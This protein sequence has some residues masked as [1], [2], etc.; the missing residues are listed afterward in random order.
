M[1]GLRVVAVDGYRLPDGSWS[2]RRGCFIECIPDA[3]VYKTRERADARIK[4]LIE[5]EPGFKHLRAKT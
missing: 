4:E 3:K 5:T 2:V 1:D